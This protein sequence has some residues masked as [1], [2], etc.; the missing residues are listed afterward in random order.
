MG[1]RRKSA[2]L[3]ALAV[4]SLAAAGCGDGAVPSSGPGLGRSAGGAAARSRAGEITLQA[5]PAAE[6]RAADLI[7]DEVLL[8]YDRAKTAFGWFY[9]TTLPSEEGGVMVGS[10]RYHPVAYPGIATLEE[11]RT[12]LRSLFSQEVIGRLLPADGIQYR[13]IDG[14][15][16]VLPSSSR[17]DPGKGAESVTAEET[18]PDAWSVNV[19]VE[20]LSEDGRDVIGMEGYSFPYENV[21]GRWVFTDFALVDAP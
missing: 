1:A 3:A 14:A 9:L 16:Y 12:Y 4:L 15:L 7:Q 18:G 20:L 6:D 10:Q 21:D 13:D 2:L 19:T 17:P 8:A 11:L 5:A